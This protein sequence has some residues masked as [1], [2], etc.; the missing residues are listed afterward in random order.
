MMKIHLLRSHYNTLVAAAAD[1]ED[2][3][4]PGWAACM[5]FLNEGGAVTRFDG[6]QFFTAPGK[7]I[8]VAASLTD[9]GVVATVL[10]WTT[11][12]HHNK[13]RERE[14]YFVE[15]FGPDGIDVTEA[16][17]ERYAL[18]HA[19]GLEESEPDPDAIRLLKKAVQ[20]VRDLYGQ[21]GQWFA[22]AAEVAM[23]TTH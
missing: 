4:S 1:V 22:S 10:V 17:F 23:A 18:F 11:E 9:A 2:T 7:V 6:G 21:G 16:L 15:T 3:P 20:Q 14:R 8:A 12:D 19:S 5:G 13:I